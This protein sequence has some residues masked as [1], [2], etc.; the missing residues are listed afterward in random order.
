MP[1]CAVA[2]LQKRS[3]SVRVTNAFFVMHSSYRATSVSIL[4]Y[5]KAHG[6][7]AESQP[8]KSAQHCRET[9]VQPMNVY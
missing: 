1:K 5:C 9:Q 8:Y 4:I 2:R 7:Q 3:A 6:P